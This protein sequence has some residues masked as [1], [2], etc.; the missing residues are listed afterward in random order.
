MTALLLIANGVG[1]LALVLVGWQLATRLADD[2]RAVNGQL[3]PQ[4]ERLV[5]EL[6]GVAATV[7]DAADATAGFAESLSQARDAATDGSRAA[8]GL[9]QAFNRLAAAGDVEIFGVRPL[10]GL[11]EPF[12]SAGAETQRLSNALDALAS[13][14]NS[15]AGDTTR[16]AADLRQARARILELAGAT[17]A[18]RAQTL[19]NQGISGLETV[20]RALLGVLLIQ[21]I[22]STLIGVAILLLAGALP[23]PPPGTSTE[24]SQ[25]ADIP[26]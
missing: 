2:L 7:E 8:A 9:S 22:L 26:G 4:Q 3:A 10:E 21:A 18:F 24:E 15:N 23:P 17:E 14:L 13:S 6:R 16:V 12:G 1:G 19:V 20:A 25:D 11:R 5:A